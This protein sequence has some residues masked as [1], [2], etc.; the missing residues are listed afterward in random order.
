MRIAGWATDRAADRDRSLRAFVVVS[1]VPT[2]LNP[3]ISS[4]SPL[5]LL[6][7]CSVNAR[8]EVAGLA[9]ENSTGDYH[10]YLLKPVGDAVLGAQAQ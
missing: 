2:G 3:L 5:H 10:G 8:G 6:T 4:N 7:A 1:G 9:A